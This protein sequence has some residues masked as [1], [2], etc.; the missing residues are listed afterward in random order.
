M[1]LLL[2]TDFDP[3]NNFQSVY[4]IFTEMFVITIGLSV[5]GQ[6]SRFLDET[7]VILR[8]VTFSTL[9]P[10]I[11]VNQ[12]MVDIEKEISRARRYE[13]PLA[14]LV[15]DT[16]ARL[17]VESR[18]GRI[19]Q[20]QAEMLDNY[21]EARVGHEILKLTRGTDIVAKAEPFGR[22]LILCPESTLQS[23]VYL[24]ERIDVIID[25]KLDAEVHWGVA[26][27]N[28]DLSTFTAACEAAS[29]DLMNRS[30]NEGVRFKGDS[31]LANFLAEYQKDDPDQQVADR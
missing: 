23:V 1:W 2:T 22:F 8:D 16:T 9:K 19:H 10:T 13:R 31:D 24:G 11:L 20:L 18:G 12:M 27:I 26:E 15:V 7:Q 17:T 28:A 6:I 21:F 14:L 30:L 3:V 5:S 4:R 25:E 29:R